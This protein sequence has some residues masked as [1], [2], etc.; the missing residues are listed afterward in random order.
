M[1]EDGLGL[2]GL[3]SG[4]GDLAFDDDGLLQLQFALLPRLALFDHLHLGLL[5]GLLAAEGGLERLH[6]A[7]EGRHSLLYNSFKYYTLAF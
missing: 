1:V 3:R 7:L 6:F 2:G 5:R 4:L